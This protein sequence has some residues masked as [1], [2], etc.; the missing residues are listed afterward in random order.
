MLG[1]TQRS[2][3]EEKLW[4]RQ[5]SPQVIPGASFGVTACVYLI[6]VNST[7]LSQET[8]QNHVFLKNIK[9]TTEQTSIY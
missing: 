3:G 9:Q 2:G 8:K 6:S 5:V 7:M 1:G 4:R